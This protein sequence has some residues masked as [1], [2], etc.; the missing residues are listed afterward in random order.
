MKRMVWIAMFA[1]LLAACLLNVTG[2]GK[3]EEAQ[4]N[5]ET[6]HEVCSHQYQ[7]TIADATCTK[8]GKKVTTCSKCGDSKIETIKAIGH[9]YQ[10]T[11]IAATCTEDGSKV[12]ACSNCGDTMSEPISATGHSYNDRQCIVCQEWKPSEGLKYSLNSDNA[13]YRVSGIGS[14]TD[15]VV[16]IPAVYNN[17]PVTSIG[18]EAFEDCTSLASII[19]P[20]SVTSIGYAAFFYCSSLAVITIPAGM[21][22]IYAHAF[23][24]CTSLTSISIPDS[25][26]SIGEKAFSGC[27][28][29]TDIY[30]EASS[31]PSGWDSGWK[32]TCPA[33]VHWGYHGD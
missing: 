7:T 25:V 21:T 4:K 1:M 30:C 6:S 15:R 2:C 12:T 28:S 5:S 19:I 29:L 32:Y 22:S 31:C 23:D 11:I 9:D 13:S 26:T 10:T 24:G 14:C 18:S 33:T 27:R 20:D 8:D 3:D 17:K 16:V